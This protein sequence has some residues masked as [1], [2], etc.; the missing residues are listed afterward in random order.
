MGSGTTV[1]TRVTS[2]GTPLF[3]SCELVP[4][5][6]NSRLNLAARGREDAKGHTRQ[7]LRG[8]ASRRLGRLLC[9]SA[10]SLRIDAMPLHL[11]CAVSMLPHPAKARTGGEDAYFI[12]EH[13]AVVAV[14]D[15]VGGWSEQGVDA[16]DF[17]REL[18]ART[19]E[20]FDLCGD[21]GSGGTDSSDGTEPALTALS[22]QAALAAGLANVRSLGTCTACLVA[23]DG[24]RSMVTA[25]NVGD[26]GFRLFRPAP[27]NG[28]AQLVAASRPQQH[29]F[30][31][32]F[33]LG[34]GSAD[35]PSDGDSYSVP[36]VAGDVLLLATDG[37]FDNLFDGE[38]AS[39]ITSAS[40]EGGEAT[41][42]VIASL[43]AKRARETSTNTRSTTP[44]SKEAA[45]HGWNM[46]GGKVDDTTVVCVKVLG[47]GVDQHVA[48]ELDAGDTPRSRL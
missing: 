19:E 11:D 44:F 38:I 18:A 43:V 37:V 31:C 14:L 15:G 32:P 27:A 48:R 41:A 2:T 21:D 13:P 45:A 35:R 1:Y 5:S 20:Q 25:L 39:L 22:L 10:M 8:S 26:S 4:V 47:G 46:P 29:S 33:Q 17:S 34:T 7:M 3:L 24:Q 40:A 6:V 23:I 12:R 30:N 9:S 42:E 28:C 16:G 36:I